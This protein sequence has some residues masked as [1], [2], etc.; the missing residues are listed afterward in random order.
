M[1]LFSDEPALGERQAAVVGHDQMIEHADVDQ[2]Q[3]LAQAPRDE[4]IGVTGLGDAGR[5]LGFV[6]ECNHHLFG[7]V[8]AV[9][10]RTLQVAPASVRGE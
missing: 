5:M 6:S 7:W 9:P 1:L 4:F 10:F 2:L 3:C 8:P